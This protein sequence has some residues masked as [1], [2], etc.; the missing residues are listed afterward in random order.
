MI[1]CGKDER[2]REVCSLQLELEWIY[3]C[4]RTESVLRLFGMEGTRANVRAGMGCGSV[5]CIE[6]TANLLLAVTMFEWVCTYIL[7]Q[8]CLLTKSKKYKK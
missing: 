2:A 3:E 7:V 1:G 5:I 4:D 6:V 8:Q